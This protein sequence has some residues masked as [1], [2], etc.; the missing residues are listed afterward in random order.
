MKAQYCSTTWT[1]SA[2]AASP[3]RPGGA[4]AVG[5]DDGKTYQLNLIDTP[6][7]VDFTYEV[8]KALQACEGACCSSTRRRASRRRP[9]RTLYLAM[10]NEAGDHPGAQQDRPAHRAPRRGRRGD[11][12]AHLHASARTAS[13]S[14]AKTGVGVEPL[15]ETDRRQDPAADRR[16]ERPLRR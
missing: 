8:S 10:E 3:S 11:R 14:P 15:L 13:R 7:H 16:S 1:S 5:P 12:D 6:G 2:S 4:D 9:S